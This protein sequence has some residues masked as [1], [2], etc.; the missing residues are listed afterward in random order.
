MTPRD[1]LTNRAFCPMPWTGIMY[2][3]DGRIK[4]CIRSAEAIGNLH[5]N[6]VTEILDQDTEI[7]NFMRKGE[8]F[9]RCKPC[10][11]LERQKNNFD[12]ISD[13]I[14]YIK[15]LRTVDTTLYSTD[16][17]DLRTV[18]IRWSN[19]C[20]F[21]CVY[22]SPE[23]S[24][25]LAS[26]TG[27]VIKIPQADQ[28]NTFKNYIF[29][30]V[31]QLK[32]VYLAGGEPLLMK[33]N[34][35]FLTLLKQK[36]PMVNLRVNTNLSHIDSGIFDLVCG[37]SNVHWVVSVESTGIQYEYIRYGGSW[38]NFMEN[39][40]TIQKLPHKISFNMLYFILNYQSLFECIELLKNLKFHNNSFILGALNDPDY[41]NVRHLPDSV[42]N[43]IK[44][45]FKDKI[46]KQPGFLL[47]D[48]LENVL[49]YLEQPIKKNLAHTF[50]KIQQLDSMRN[51]DS[52]QI[53][54]DLYK[55]EIYGQTI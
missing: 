19:L 41:L 24:S 42:L 39:L 43:C 5:D 31:D 38:T 33:E 13:R 53:F 37:F 52:R 49:N 26:E 36:N 32:H 4:N 18:D 27:T 17:H 45:V 11:D 47:Q 48:G 1:I 55:E 40:L 7:K 46:N 44:N 10:Y 51:L 15:E 22:C 12:I 29:E 34:Y 6:S 54:A 25:R 8:K 2:N 30:R 20:N 16:Q 21:A 35:E 9:K 3:V 23:F 14:F 50:E 28:R